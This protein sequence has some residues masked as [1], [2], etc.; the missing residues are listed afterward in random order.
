MRGLM[1]PQAGDQC[2]Q[3]ARSARVSHIASRTLGVFACQKA[4]EFP[5]RPWSH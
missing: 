5:A 4:T 3:A 1:R 2:S